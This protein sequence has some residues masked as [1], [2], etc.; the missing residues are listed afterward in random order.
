MIGE[1]GGRR[2]DLDVRG[3]QHAGVLGDDGR[4]RAFGDVSRWPLTPAQ[5]FS[6]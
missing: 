4:G 5:T 6:P 1:R 3:G 2:E